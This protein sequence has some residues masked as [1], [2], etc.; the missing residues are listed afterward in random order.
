MGI[1]GDRYRLRMKDTRAFA[2]FLDHAAMAAM[3]AAKVADGEAQVTGDGFRRLPEA[4]VAA[5]VQQIVAG[6]MESP[7]GPVAPLRAPAPRA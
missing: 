4:E 6:R 2:N 3:N 5:A 1:E 7:D